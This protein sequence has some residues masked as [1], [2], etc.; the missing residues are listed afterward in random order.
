MPPM[1]P[2]TRMPAMRTLA[3]RRP[4][5]RMLQCRIPLQ[6]PILRP[7][8]QLPPLP[9]P[10]IRMLQYRT[11]LRMLSLR[12]PLLRIPTCLTQSFRVPSH[13]APST[14]RGG[15]Q[16][17]IP[18]TSRNRLKQQAARLRARQSTCRLTTRTRCPTDTRS[19]QVLA[20]VCTTRREASSTTTRS[21]KSGCLAKRS[22]RPT[23]SSRP[24]D[25]ANPR[26]SAATLYL[27]D[28]RDD[29]AK[30]GC[31]IARYGIERRVVRH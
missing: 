6:T 23:A 24:T 18:R 27:A 31:V 8:P 19:R 12:R 2:R 5:I 4:G 21:P 11:P 29:L 1:R 3:M 26:D 25:P 10:D 15:T 14:G 13:P 7:A 28:H 16:P 17:W 20:S 9:R 30:H 22:L